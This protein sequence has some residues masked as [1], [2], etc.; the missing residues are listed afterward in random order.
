VIGNPSNIVE[1]ALKACRLVETACM[2]TQ[3]KV[4]AWHTA[5]RC[6]AVTFPPV[7]KSASDFRLLVYAYAATA[8]K[9]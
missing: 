1:G 9:T 5:G 7:S 4:V 6:F 3:R 2:L 8:G